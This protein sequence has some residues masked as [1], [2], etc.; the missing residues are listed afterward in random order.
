MTTFCFEFATSM[1]KADF[2]VDFCNFTKNW[3]KEVDFWKQ[4][5]IHQR[6]NKICDRKF[7]ARNY[8]SKCSNHIFSL[9]M[10]VSGSF[11]ELSQP[12]HFSSVNSGPFIRNIFVH[13]ANSGVIY[14]IAS[15][16]L[17][18]HCGF[19]VKDHGS[20]SKIFHCHQSDFLHFLDQIWY[21]NLHKNACSW[22]CHGIWVLFEG[23]K[24][25]CLSR[26]ISTFM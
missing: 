13:S 4:V 20:I 21:I 12:S 16:F 3:P 1:T 24:H 2:F 8:C 14:F 5:V 25:W 17:T 22:I 11:F 6:L 26:F 10:W 15:F 7:N 19:S 18:W 9:Y 23:V